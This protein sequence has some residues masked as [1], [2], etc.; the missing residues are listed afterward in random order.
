[1]VLR[2]DMQ[3]MTWGMSRC[4]QLGHGDT[5]THRTPQKVAALQPFRVIEIAAGAEHSIAVT[6]DGNAWVWGKCAD[7]Q[8]G[9]GSEENVLV[10]T[11]VGELSNVVTCAAGVRH[12][13]FLNNRGIVFVCGSDFPGR[14]T[15]TPTQVK[16]PFWTVAI[17]TGPY[18]TLAICEN[19]DGLGQDHS[20]YAWGSAKNGVLGLTDVETCNTP[21]LIRFL[22]RRQMMAVSFGCSDL[23]FGVIVRGK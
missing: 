12:S 6:L 15:L 23:A 14:K 3:L 8:L 9:L 2:E 13:V 21:Q 22:E 5:E 7:G 4:G 1:M 10:P 19:P 16:L 17:H 20:T 11:H 18:H